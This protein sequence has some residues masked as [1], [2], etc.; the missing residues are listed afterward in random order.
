M[1]EF[2]NSDMTQIVWKKKGQGMT[3][4]KTYSVRQNGGGSG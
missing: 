4:K 1:I 3:F 2:A